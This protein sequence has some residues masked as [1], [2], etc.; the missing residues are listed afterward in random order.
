MNVLA[1]TIDEKRCES[2]WVSRKVSPREAR[3]CRMKG[4]RCIAGAVGRLRAPWSL[5]DTLT[6]FFLSSSYASPY[7]PLS[8]PLWPCFVPHL[9]PYPLHSSGANRRD[10]AA[11]P[12]KISHAVGF[13]A[14]LTLDCPDVFDSLDFATGLCPDLDLTR[15][16]PSLALPLRFFEMEFVGVCGC[17]RMIEMVV[18]CL[19]DPFLEK[20]GFGLKISRSLK[21][22]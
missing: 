6:S 12:R 7:L 21:V 20:G 14:E 4:G 22:K 10:K 18:D 19:Y 8:I 13:S 5:Q 17:W 9:D 11:G 2:G 1:R 3:C 15:K 16:R